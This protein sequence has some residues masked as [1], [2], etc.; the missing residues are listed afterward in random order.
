MAVPDIA[1]HCAADAS[2]GTPHCTR[3][4][5]LTYGGVAHPMNSSCLVRLC[6]VVVYTQRKK[7]GKLQPDPHASAPNQTV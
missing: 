1:Q 7:V 3:T 2:V 5:H 4:G 6:T